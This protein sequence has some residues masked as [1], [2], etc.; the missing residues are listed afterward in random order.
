ML[1]VKVAECEAP[2]ETIEIPVESQG[3]ILMSTLSAQFP[4]ACGLK[5][6]T[7]QNSWRGY[8]FILIK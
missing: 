8:S 2:E 3:F 6:K 4:G 5:I 1:F 7:G